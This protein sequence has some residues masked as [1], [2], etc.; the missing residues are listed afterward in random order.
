MKLNFHAHLFKSKMNGMI[1][2]IKNEEKQCMRR[3]KCSFI[4]KNGGK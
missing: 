4:N 3:S 2:E 1:M